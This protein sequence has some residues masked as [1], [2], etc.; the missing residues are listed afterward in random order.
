MNVGRSPRPIRRKA[1]ALGRWLALAVPLNEFEEIRR[2]FGK[3]GQGF[4]NHDRFLGGG[5]VRRAPRRTVGR[6]ALAL[7]QEDRL[8]VFAA[9]HG[10]VALK[11][12][13]GWSIRAEE[14]EGKINMVELETTHLEHKTRAS[15]AAL[16]QKPLT[17]GG[18]SVRGLL[19]R[20]ED[21]FGGQDN[22]GY[23]I[24]HIAAVAA[25]QVNCAGDE[26]H[27]DVAIKGAARS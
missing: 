12:H 7:H 11:E 6:N 3:I 22:R 4:M 16:P 21:L 1:W 8:V 18:R 26:T 15:T 23:A 9:Q 20:F 17:M 2:K 14:G 10:V 13:D 27:E 25:F 19:G 24:A 5:C